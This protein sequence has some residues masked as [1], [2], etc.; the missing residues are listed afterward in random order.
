MERTLSFYGSH[1]AAAAFIDK[2]HEI[3]ILEYERMTRQRYAMYSDRFDSRKKIGTD[4]KSRKHFVDYIKANMLD[5]DIETI[6]YNELSKTDLAL[7]GKEFPNA[8]FKK[9]GHHY[10]HAACAY[11]QSPFDHFFNLQ[12][13]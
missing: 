12:G 1:D 9:A 11:F 8:Q 6:I 3:K 10:S 13:I 2:N 7:L 4:H 5:S